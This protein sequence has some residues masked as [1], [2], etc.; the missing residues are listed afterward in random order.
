M[1]TSRLCGKNKEGDNFVGT[2]RDERLEGSLFHETHLS[3]SF[4][5]ILPSQQKRNKTKTRKNM[6]KKKTRRPLDAV[7]D[8][9][10]YY[11]CKFLPRHSLAFPRRIFFNFHICVENIKRTQTNPLH[12]TH[13]MHT[14]GGGSGQYAAVKNKPRRAKGLMFC[15]TGAVIQ[16]KTGE[17]NPPKIRSRKKSQKKR[18]SPLLSPLQS[19][20]LSF[21]SFSSPICIESSSLPQCDATRPPHHVERGCQSPSPRREVL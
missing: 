16:L 20:S 18:K 8:V 2:K 3:R 12:T 13:T 14:G 19:I 15:G 1:H 7:D 9:T 21:F 4:C 5:Y 6:K 17:N 10:Y 11:R